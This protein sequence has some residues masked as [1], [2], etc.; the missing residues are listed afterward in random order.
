MKKNILFMLILAISLIFLLNGCQKLGT[1]CPSPGVC[2]Y[3]EEMEE[4]ME[5][6]SGEI[7]V[8]TEEIEEE[9]PEE[10]EE[11]LPEEADIIVTE[12]ELVKLAPK[13]TD[14]EGDIITFTFSEPLNENGEWLTEIG[15]A[16]LYKT[17]VIA[18]DGVNEVSQEVTILVKPANKPPIMEFIEDIIVTEGD[19]VTIEPVVSDPEGDNIVISYSGWMT[20]SSYETTYEDAGEYIVTV[21]AS[22]GVNEVSQ[23]VNI[24]VNEFNR[25]PVMEKIDDMFLKEGDPVAVIVDATDPDG[26]ELT[27]TFSEPLDENGEWLTEIGDA[28]SYGITVT[29]SDGISEV[30]QDFNIVVEAVNRPPVIEIEDIIE[31]NEGETVVLEPI[32]T[33]PDEDEVEIT[34]SGWMTS[35]TYETTYEDAG[36]HIVTITADD[37]INQ[38]TKD[39]TV[40]VNDI[41]RPPEFT[42]PY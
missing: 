1:F 3:P 14:P 5:E 36:E 22:D 40:K 7:I 13:A 35:D 18:S 29:A 34:Y 31:L 8:P 33:D 41:N 9:V 17:I 21:T 37:G 27:I 19:T 39:V 10:V 6:I 4:G 20:T 26:D 2:V 11:E 25:P 15:D 30:S 16:G 12:G 24:I 28:G 38:V 23:N 42:K 32:V